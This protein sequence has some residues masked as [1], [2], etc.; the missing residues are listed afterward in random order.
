[1]TKFYEHTQKHIDALIPYVNNA[2]THDD[3]QI[4]QIIASIREWGFTNPILIDEN[5]NVIA[6]HGRLMAADKMN[7]THVPCII[8]TGLTEA[9]KKAYVLADNQLALNAGWNEQLLSLE[10]QA[11]SEMDFNLDLLGFDN[12][13]INDAL[14]NVDFSAGSE[15][16]QGQLD[17]LEPKLV[18]CP[19]CGQEFDLRGE[20]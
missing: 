7:M 12:D 16:D 1:M 13:A 3:N 9:Q 20:E 15:D 17:E 6:G 19:H 4:N 14:G 5:D 18:T 11:L 10:V 8:M 2:R